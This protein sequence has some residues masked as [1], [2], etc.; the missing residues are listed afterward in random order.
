MSD[1]SGNDAVSPPFCL[2]LVWKSTSLS[3]VTP[4]LE[5]GEKALS[6]IHS[7]PFGF[8]SQRKFPIM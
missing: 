4:A 5:F 7:L 3:S 6:F 8:L 2:T 1:F